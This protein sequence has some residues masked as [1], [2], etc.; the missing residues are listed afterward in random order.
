MIVELQ[1][2]IW[3]ML[4]RCTWC[5]GRKGPWKPYLGTIIVLDNTR[6]QKYTLLQRE[7]Q[8]C[9]KAPA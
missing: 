5:G 6:G 9:G 2:A 4:G 8:H 3:M 1:R 7:C